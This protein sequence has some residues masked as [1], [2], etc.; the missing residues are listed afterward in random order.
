VCRKILDLLK[1]AYPVIVLLLF[2]S[3]VSVKG[4]P[5][6]TSKNWKWNSLYYIL[7]GFTIKMLFILLKV[8]IYCV[9]SF[10]ELYMYIIL[11]R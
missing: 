2:N 5:R 8:C 3:H 11:Y 6:G 10:F 7:E 1:V 4:M 9:A